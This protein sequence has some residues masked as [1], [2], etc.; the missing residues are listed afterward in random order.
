MKVVYWN[1]IPSP[2]MVDRFNRIAARGNVDLVVWFT[3]RTELDRSWAVDE[4]EWQFRHAYVG[5][6]A[7]RA[8]ARG[9][10][11]LRRERPDV[12]FCLYEKPEYVAVALGAR[13]S[14]IPVVMRALKILEAWRPKRT[15]REVAKSLL[16]P[17]VSGFQVPGPDAADYVHG[18][19]VPR[20]RIA[21]F[22]EPVDVDR[23]RG[24]TEQRW[25]REQTSA[26][27]CEFLYVGRLLCSKGIDYL[28]DA[29][30]T[31]AENLPRVSLV[32]AGDG[33]DAPRYRARAAALPG[34]RFVGYAEG[35]ELVERYASADVLVFPTLADGYGHVVEEA[36]AAGLPVISTT[37]AGD[38]SERVVEGKTGLLVPPADSKR[39]AE[40]MLTLAREPA[41]RVE[42]G[43]RGLRRIESRTLDWWAERFELLAAEV[44]G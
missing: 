25:E 12:L 27:A 6:D 29:Y 1:N 2:Y 21:V 40:A 26:S 20:S 8:A 9:V 7:L 15:S 24:A 10:R 31:V 18:Y 22:P 37:A 42:M 11:M 41:V 4:A 32:V 3:Q 13:V 38:V 23:F 44:A 14:G 34:V 39:L 28:L 35:A 17:R 16:F 30:A 19:G 5:T 36:M 43:R 33:D